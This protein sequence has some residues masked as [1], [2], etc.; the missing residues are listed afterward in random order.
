MNNYIF[1][2]LDETLIHT[3]QPFFGDEPS[4]DAVKVKI[5]GEKE[6]YDTILRQGAVYFLHELRARGKVYMLTAATSDYAAAMNAQFGFGFT[7]QDIYAREDIAAG[8]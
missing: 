7:S 8:N 5:P 3:L 6:D 1:V 2:D 4:K